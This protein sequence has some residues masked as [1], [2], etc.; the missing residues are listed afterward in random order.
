[1]MVKFWS[2]EETESVKKH[3]AYSNLPT[4]TFEEWRH[5]HPN[6]TVHIGVDPAAERG[7]ESWELTILQCL[8]T[9]ELYVKKIRKL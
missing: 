7:D 6:Y 5:M 1:M 2:I 3:K 9:S 8:D 4:M